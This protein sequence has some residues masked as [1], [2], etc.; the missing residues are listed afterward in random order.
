MDP[1]ERLRIVYARGNE[2]KE[3][4]QRD[5]TRI[6]EESLGRAG[7]QLAYNNAK[8]P[9]PRIAFAAALPSG[10]TSDAE[11]ADIDTASHICAEDL[12]LNTK[13]HLPPG[14]RIRTAREVG[15]TGATLQTL[16]RW[17]E[18]LVEAPLA[19]RSKADVRAAIARL[20][21]ADSL[22]WEHARENR[23]SRYDLRQQVLALELAE[24]RGDSCNLM[25]R[26]RITSER[27]GR[28][29]QVALAC[30]F[31]DPPASIHRTNLYI[32]PLP[33]AI[34][35]YNDMVGQE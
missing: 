5:M 11:V 18:Y 26:L 21:T 7:I 28:P 31:V 30:G 4:S 25:M 9:A 19:G 13:P 29:E 20:I 23:I 17:A 24:I 34:R 32:D 2:L 16:V 6:W 15:L 1:I 3:A 33:V 27:A 14:L 12:I 22:P 10:A 8:R 35:K